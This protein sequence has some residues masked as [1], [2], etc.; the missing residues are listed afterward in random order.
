MRRFSHF[1]L[2]PAHTLVEGKRL[3][4]FLPKQALART[5]AGVSALA[6]SRAFSLASVGGFLLQ[7]IFSD[8]NTKPASS[9]AFVAPLQIQI[10]SL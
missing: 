2:Q 10:P 7:A 3:L 1:K 4:L 6:L 5:A 8:R 9:T